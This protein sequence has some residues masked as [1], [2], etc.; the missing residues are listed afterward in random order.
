MATC[1][2]GRYDKNC[3]S[4]SLV[5]RELKN[6]VSAVNITQTQFVHVHVNLAFCSAFR[7]FGDFSHHTAGIR[8]LLISYM[9]SKHSVSQILDIFMDTLLP[10][11][12]L[13]L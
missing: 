6:Q 11:G 7:L 5:E 13:H 9:Q 3:I 10:D 2:A 8:H 4:R 1:R 12:L